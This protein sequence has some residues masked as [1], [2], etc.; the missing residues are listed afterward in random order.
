MSRF[1]PARRTAAFHLPQPPPQARWPVLALLAA[2]AFGLVT[3]WCDSVHAADDLPTVTKE[4]RG[5]AVDALQQTLR[6]EER[7]V[8]VH[9]AEFLL[10]LDYPDDVREVFEEELARSGDEPEYRIGIWRVLARAAARPEDRESWTAKIRDVFLDVDAPDRLHA[11]ETLAKLRYKAPEGEAE[12]FEQ[13]ARQSEGP[14]A[15][16]ANWVLV[17]SGVD[18]A[19]ARL[20]DLLHSPEPGRRT[21]AQYALR[22]LA[23][24][25]TATRTRLAD[26]AVGEPEDASGRV[27]LVS[28]A[29]VHAPD[30]YR[31]AWKDQLLVYAAEGE[32]GEK[33][34]ACE[35]LSAIGSHED[36][37]LLISLLDDPEADVRSAAGCA[38]LRIGRRMPHRMTPLDWA[39]IAVY[40]VGMIG[41]GWYYAR[42]TASAEDYLLGGRNMKPLNVGLSLF[43]TLLST[44]SYLTWP[45]E[46]IRYGPLFMMGAI[47]SYPVIYVVTGWFMIP[48]I[49]KLK[50]TSAY[51][52]LESRLGPAVRMLG[53]LLFL[54][55]RLAWMAVII[56]ATSDKVLVPLMGWTSSAT[57][58]VC[59]V[60]GAITVIYTSMGGLRAVVLTDVVQTLILFGGAILTLVLVSVYLGGVTAW[61]PTGWM[62]HWPEPV[63]GYQPGARITFFGGFL[64]TFTWYICTSGSDQMAIQRYLATRDVKAARFVLATSLVAST[65]V[66]IIMISV[67]LAIYAYFRVNPHLLPD[68]QT[69]LSDADSLF[70]QFIAF[71]IPVGLSGLVV[72][73]LLAAAM[74]SL[75]SGINSSCSVVTVDFV[76]RFRSRR[77]GQPETDHVKLARYVSVVVGVVVVVLSSGVGMV[78]GNLL[79]IAFKVVNLLTAPLFGLFFMA[80]FVRWATAPGTLIGAVF[81]LAVVV[82]VNF[83][84]EITGTP[85][86]SFIWAM[87]LGL[88]VQVGVG[89][90]ASLLPMGRR[91]GE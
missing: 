78:E 21:A 5:R 44:I 62:P 4:L 85:G 26:A 25:S 45:G 8:K 52:I 71:G 17:N 75:S 33:Y 89:M 77:P 80:M 73:G 51:E 65:L 48:F 13:A 31:V 39:V 14:M 88:V 24:L 86:I 41:V 74:S 58:Y 79:E 47:V 84:K 3:S 64:A 35:T 91:S 61:W 38:I 32:P 70:P 23:D 30:D 34:Q 87:P 42:R 12:P 9:A 27:F 49:M 18:G 50:V 57:P 54:S 69:M 67:G 46:T 66:T 2:V 20:A 10:A 90:V 7:W 81:G 16:Y 56:F 72:A 68:G 59:M 1:L 55:L 76:E 37:S 6:E 28:A 83:W 82:A 36:L 60:L 15:A 40:G 43:A 11:V 53:S 29:V 63:W 22:H 19:E